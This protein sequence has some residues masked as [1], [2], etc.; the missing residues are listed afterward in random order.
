MRYPHFLPDN[1]SIG[2]ISPSFGAATEPYRSAFLNACK[3]FEAL[4][5]RCV[6]GPKDRKSVV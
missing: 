4:G 6:S 5:Y 2:F 3:H 1:G